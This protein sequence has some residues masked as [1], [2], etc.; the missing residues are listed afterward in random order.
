MTGPFLEKG[1]VNSGEAEFPRYELSVDIVTDETREGR[2]GSP[3]AEKDRRVAGGTSRGFPR[4]P[5]FV[6][7]VFPGKLGKGK[8]QIPGRVPDAENA[9]GHGLPIPSPRMRMRRRRTSP[10]RSL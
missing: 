2:G 9:S 1:D 5:D 10:L 3:E 6:F 8:I 7:G 4:I